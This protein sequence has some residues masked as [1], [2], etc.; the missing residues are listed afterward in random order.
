MVSQAQSLADIQCDSISD[1]EVPGAEGPIGARLYVPEGAGDETL[2][3]LI[4]IHG[5]GFMIGA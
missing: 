2:P 4:F 3:G 1:L 5:G